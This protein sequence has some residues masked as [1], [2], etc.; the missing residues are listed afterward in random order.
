MHAMTLASNQEL[1]AADPDFPQPTLE[2][3]AA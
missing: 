2:E 3:L 1:K